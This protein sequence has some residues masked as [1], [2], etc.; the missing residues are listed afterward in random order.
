MPSSALEAVA[1]TA[2]EGRG[3]LGTALSM[4]LAGALALGGVGHADTQVSRSATL[5]L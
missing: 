4:S 3:A 5:K 1:L 2:G